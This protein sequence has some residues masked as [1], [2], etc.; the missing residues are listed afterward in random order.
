MRAERLTDVPS[1]ALAVPVPSIATADIAAAATPTARRAFRILPP[2]SHVPVPSSGLPVGSPL[3]N[4][5]T[6]G[7]T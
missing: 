1:A 6:Y 4:R 3:V 7:L 5:S 2:L